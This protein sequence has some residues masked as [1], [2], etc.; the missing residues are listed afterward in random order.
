MSTF[1]LLIG[2][3]EFSGALPVV[4]E[5]HSITMHSTQEEAEE[6]GEYYLNKGA[7]SYVV[8]TDDRQLDFSQLKTNKHELKN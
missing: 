5:V 8:Y 7:D 6:E 3:I 4:H 1:Y 2:V